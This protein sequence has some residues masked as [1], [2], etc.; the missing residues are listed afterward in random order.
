MVKSIQIHVAPTEKYK[1]FAVIKEIFTIKIINIQNFK[2]YIY[3]FITFF[4]VVCEIWIKCK[5]NFNKLFYFLCFTQYL[6]YILSLATVRNFLSLTKWEKWIQPSF[7]VYDFWN[8]Q[9]FD[10]VYSGW[11]CTVAQH[12]WNSYLTMTEW[13]LMYLISSGGSCYKVLNLL[14]FLGRT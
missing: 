6:I 3:I 10:T 14:F 1:L 5:C 9:Y 13:I 11:Y 12:I 7:C 2:G 8:H 4:F